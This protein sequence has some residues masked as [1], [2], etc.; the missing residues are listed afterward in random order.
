MKRILSTFLIS[1]ILLLIVFP[2][3]N[4]QS[5]KQ[6]PLSEMSDVECLEFL[7]EHGIEIPEY[8]LSDENIDW[9]IEYVLEIIAA[10]EKDPNATLSTGYSLTP[11]FFEE[12]RA[13]VNAYYGIDSATVPPLPSRYTL[14][15]STVLLPWQESF[16]NYN[17]YGFVL[18]RVSYVN[19]GYYSGNA[20]YSYLNV[21][22][23]DI[24]ADYVKQDLKSMEF[25]YDCVKITT[26]RPT[27]QSLFPGQTAICLRRGMSLIYNNHY[28]FHVMLLVG[29]NWHHKP[30]NTQ[31]L[32]YLSLPTSSTYWYDE[33][34]YKNIAY[35]P[36]TIYTGGLR[37][38]IFKPNHG[39]TTTVYTGTNYHDGFTHYYLYSEGCPHC[40][41]LT[42]YFWQSVPC[43]IVPCTIS[44]GKGHE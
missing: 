40:D 31:P 34:V 13:A 21:P 36:V 6:Q 43:P 11:T 10:V 17:C 1:L 27:Q 2:V 39:T 42:E 29:S 3:A 38:I 19:P 8:F 5:Y 7:D 9:L 37:Y 16:K 12:I 41:D 44:G 14:Q 22:S 26:I 32:Q 15:Y 30:G 25:S 35:A 24:L 33:H 18:N 4:A 23:L 28:D 20:G